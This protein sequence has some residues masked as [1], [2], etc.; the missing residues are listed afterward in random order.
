MYEAGPF[1]YESIIT[2]HFIQRAGVLKID[3]CFVI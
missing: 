2:D 3:F 1:V